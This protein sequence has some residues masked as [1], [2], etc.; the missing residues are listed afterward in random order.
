MLSVLPDIHCV[1]TPIV[2]GASICVC[3]VLSVLPDIPYVFAFL[4]VDVSNY[5]CHVLCM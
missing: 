1:F 4:V 5:V 3:C 2:V